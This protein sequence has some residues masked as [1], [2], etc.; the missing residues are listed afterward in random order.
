MDNVRVGQDSTF[1][2]QG[3]AMKRPG[4]SSGGAPAGLVCNCRCTLVFHEEKI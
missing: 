1:N 3:Y 4:D 2:V